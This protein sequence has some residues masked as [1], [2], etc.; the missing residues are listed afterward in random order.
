MKWDEILKL[1]KNQPV[2]ET[3]M[4]GDG[5]GEISKI[6]VQVSRWVKSGRLTQVRR[7]IY[8]LSD[9]Y[10]ASP[11]NR[12]YIAT[13][14]KRPSYVSLE[15]ALSNYGLIP[16]YV[17]NITLVTTRRPARLKFANNYF[18]Y[19]HIMPRLFWGYI[20]KGER[21]FEIFYAEPEKA[22]LDLFYLTDGRLD[23]VYMEEMRFQNTE[24]L[25]LEK[26]M[27]YARRFDRPKITAAAGLFKKFA[28]KERE[29]KEL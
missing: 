18:I 11:S 27:G 16:E 10:K 7:G 6:R 8:A 9:N 23:S 15:Y 28:E 2:I 29:M 14:A 3:R 17:P 1:F 20:S 24:I 5:P 19:K 22:I 25:D 12:E 21:N 4:L 13:Y 26:L